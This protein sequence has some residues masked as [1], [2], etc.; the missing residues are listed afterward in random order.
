MSVYP[1]PFSDQ[2]NITFTINERKYIRFVVYDMQGRIAEVLVED[3]YRPGKHVLSFTDAGLS[4]GAYIVRGECSDGSVL[5]TERII[6][7]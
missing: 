6:A 1:N 4:S 7:E 2:I 5:F 3:Y